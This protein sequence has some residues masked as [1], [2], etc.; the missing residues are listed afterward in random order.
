MV[1]QLCADWA[2][3][4]AGH[5]IWL[6]PD[7]VSYAQLGLY[8]IHGRFGFSPLLNARSNPIS[9]ASQVTPTLEPTERAREARFE[10]IFVTFNEA[11][12]KYMESYVSLQGQL[13]EVLKAAREVSWLAATDE[14]KLSEINQVQRELFAGMPRRLD[15]APLGQITRDLGSAPSKIAELEAALT[16]GEEGCRSLEAAI[17]LMKEK[18]EEMKEAMRTAGSP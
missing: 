3:E 13:Y 15:Y 6:K 12:K 18:V 11:W 5:S 4:V 16:L 9:W 14:R 1:S 8:L 2:N 17:A 7:S 10:E